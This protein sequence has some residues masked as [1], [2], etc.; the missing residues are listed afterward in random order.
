MDQ[1]SIQACKR[2]QRRRYPGRHREAPWM[3]S[4]H[5]GIL[6][7]LNELRRVLP[8]K[9]S[10]L[11]QGRDCSSSTYLRGLEGSLGPF[12]VFWT[13]SEQRQN[14]ERV[15]RGRLEF[16]ANWKLA[17]RRERSRVG[18]YPK[19]MRYL[20]LVEPTSLKSYYWPHV[21]PN[22]T[23]QN[24]VFGCSEWTKIYPCQTE[25]TSVMKRRRNVREPGTGNSLKGKFD[26]V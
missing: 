2:R 17:G 20:N 15:H 21:D 18:M 22:C 19:S 3:C 9:A 11:L 14:V 8:R 4:S 23:H 5:G 24:R 13:I 12:N 25:G 16:L 7:Q 26:L 10:I 1:S 6:A